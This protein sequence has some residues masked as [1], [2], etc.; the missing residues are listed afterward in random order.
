MLSSCS[1]FILTCDNYLTVPIYAWTIQPNGVVPTA[2]CRSVEETLYFFWFVLTNQGHILTSALV[3]WVCWVTLDQTHVPNRCSFG[4]KKLRRGYHL[5]QCVKVN[6]NQDP[7]SQA[8]PWPSSLEMLHQRDFI[9][10]QIVFWR[11][12]SSESF[13]LCNFLLNGILLAPGWIK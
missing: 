1:T 11:H 13:P 3:S 2:L 8:R 5:K 4:Q 6:S 9:S 7:P 10:I 12:C